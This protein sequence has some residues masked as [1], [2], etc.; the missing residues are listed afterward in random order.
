MQPYDYYSPRVVVAQPACADD[1]GV[2]LWSIFIAFFLVLLVIILA[3]AFTPGG[4]RACRRQCPGGVVEVTSRP[5]RTRAG[6]CS[7]CGGASPATAEANHVSGPPPKLHCM[8]NGA[9]LA[10]MFTSD[11]TRPPVQID[12]R[13]AFVRSPS[14]CTKP[15]QGGRTIEIQSP[16]ELP[17][18]KQVVLAVTSRNCSHCRKMKDNLKN[19]KDSL[20]TDVYI[21]D[22]SNNKKLAEY[23]KVQELAAQGVPC[24]AEVT[25]D[26]KNKDVV[27]TGKKILGNN[28]LQ[29]EQLVM[30]Q[31]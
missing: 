4:W 28:Q 19:N 9:N 20:K 27:V 30:H 31:S 2:A 18:E 23:P 14:P 24:T 12:T 7:S 15:S 10:A 25:F 8:Q 29:I 11:Q 16:E 5:I 13:M 21:L 3:L 26:H 1:D 17:K 22:I 6:S